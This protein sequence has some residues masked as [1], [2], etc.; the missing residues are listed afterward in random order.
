MMSHEPMSIED[1]VLINFWINPEEVIIFLFRA[2]S[3]TNP[4]QRYLLNSKFMPPKR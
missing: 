1:E 2:L 4:S 3:E